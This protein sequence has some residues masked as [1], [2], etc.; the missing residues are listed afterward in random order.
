MS[1]T[2]KKFISALAVATLATGAIGTASA[3][4][5]WAS[6]PTWNGYW[7]GP[8]IYVARTM[9]LRQCQLNTP[10]GEYCHIDNCDY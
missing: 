2:F 3:S 10:Y 9:A 6:S 8:N 7:I 5:C 1:A 4:T